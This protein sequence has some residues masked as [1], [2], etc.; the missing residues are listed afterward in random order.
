MPLAFAHAIKVTCSLLFL[1]FLACFS[2][3]WHNERDG[4]PLH[5]R[6]VSS[7]LN[8]WSKVRPSCSIT[9]LSSSQKGPIAE[10]SEDRDSPCKTSSRIPCLALNFSSQPKLALNESGSASGYSDLNSVSACSW[11]TQVERVHLSSEVEQTRLTRRHRAEEIAKIERCISASQQREP[12]Q[13]K[14]KS[15]F[16]SGPSKYPPQSIWECQKFQTLGTARHPFS[17]H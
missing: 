9:A 15:R 8:T 10:T 17:T 3:P 2:P 16:S 7:A 5:R 14:H 11:M 12:Q 13:K 6:P 4:R 1:K